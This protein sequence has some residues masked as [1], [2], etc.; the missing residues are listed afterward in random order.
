MNNGL[1]KKD[2]DILN[3]TG[4]DFSSAG[5]KEDKV[6]ET[7]NSVGQ[8]VHDV[9]YSGAAACTVSTINTKGEQSMSQG[10]YSHQIELLQN[11]QSYL[12]E[13]QERLLG[14]SSNYA[15]KVDNLHAEGMMLETYERYAENELQETQQLI[16]R[17]VDHISQSDIPAVKRA[18]ELCEAAR[19]G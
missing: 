14:V 4:D 18:V 5:S 10:S 8:Q 17:L 16:R 3:L 19:N 2:P 9:L 11:L 1:T 12:G 6:Q 15:R 13:F 7:K